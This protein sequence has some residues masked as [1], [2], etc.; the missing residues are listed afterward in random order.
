MLSISPNSDNDAD[1][2]DNGDQE[3]DQANPEP[4]VHS[5]FVHVG[6]ASSRIHAFVAVDTGN[7][8][9]EKKLFIPNLQKIH[10]CSLTPESKEMFLKEGSRYDLTANLLS[11]SVG[12]SVYR[13]GNIC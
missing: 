5:S 1:D 3:N 7:M 12:L 8:Q 2:D 6:T 4:V 9:N 11:R 10:Y 13:F